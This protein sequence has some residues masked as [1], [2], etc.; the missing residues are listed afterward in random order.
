MHCI[1]ANAA[2]KPVGVVSFQTFPCIEVAPFP[3]DIK[4]CC[5][6]DRRLLKCE[7]TWI[8]RCNQGSYRWD[9][10]SRE[11][12]RGQAIIGAARKVTDRF[13]LVVGGTGPAQGHC[14]RLFLTETTPVLRSG[15]KLGVAGK[16]VREAARPSSGWVPSK[17]R[18]QG[19]FA[20]SSTAGRKIRPFQSN[21]MAHT[22]S[23]LSCR[24]QD[25]KKWRNLPA[26]VDMCKGR[27]RKPAERGFQMVVD[28][29]D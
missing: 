16:T 4:D 2:L 8:D 24:V 5:R 21:L 19:T 12:I 26:S 11:G 22:A 6:L 9:K 17:S 7:F 18:H 27:S 3:R 13:R 20:R 15:P 14:R 29:G 10:L 25:R 28:T 1:A 23:G